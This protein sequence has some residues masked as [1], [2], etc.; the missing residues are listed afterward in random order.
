MYACFLAFGLRQE[1][2]CLCHFQ[3]TWEGQGVQQLGLWT[4]N[5]SIHTFAPGVYSKLHNFH[6]VLLCCDA[7]K[8]ASYDCSHPA[9]V[10]RNTRPSRLI[11]SFLH[12]SCLHMCPARLYT[13]HM[14]CW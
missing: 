6:I 12:T 11:G 10:L 14:P 8:A 4:H 13:Q 9:I 3:G 5:E 2:M 7:P 1:R